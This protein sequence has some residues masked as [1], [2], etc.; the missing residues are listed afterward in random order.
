MNFTHNFTLV[1]GRNISN[2]ANP[3][4]SK[5]YVT[6]ED[7]QGFFNGVNALLECYTLKH[8]NGVWQGITEESFSIEVLGNQDD[9]ELIGNLRIIA[10]QYKTA[11]YQDSVLFTVTPVS[12]VDFI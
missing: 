9:T 1:F 7:L 10:N 6:D 11:Y 12:L 2:A 5:D 3:D 4:Q 8:F